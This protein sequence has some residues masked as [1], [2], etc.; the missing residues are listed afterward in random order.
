MKLNKLLILTYFSFFSF[1]AIFAQSNPN[2]YVFPI[3]TGQQNFLS[4]NMGE[5]R[6]NHFHAGIDIKTS[7]VEGLPVYAAAD[8]YISRIKM[9]AWGYG[10]AL[11][12]QHP[13]GETTVYAHLLR[14]ND[15]I[16]DYVRAQQYQQKTFE[17]ELFPEKNV[18]PISQGD[19]IAFSGNTGGSGGPHLHFE[20][21]D[22]NQ[23][24]LN[25]LSYTFSEIVDD[26]P[27][28]IDRIA[29]ITLEKDARINNQF[30]RFEFDLV[31][32]G[33]KYLI[34]DPIIVHGEVGIEVLGYDRANGT[35][36]KNGISIFETFVDDELLFYQDIAKFS[37]AESR[38]ILVFHNY[39][40]YRQ[41]GKRF[42]KLYVDEGNTLPFYERSPGKGRLV[43]KDSSS[44][45]ITIN[46]WDIYKNKSSIE[47]QLIS[48]PPVSRLQSSKK[49][50]ESNSSE[51]LKN[52]LKIT[53]AIKEGAGNKAFFHANRMVFDENPAYINNTHGVYLWD[54]K[55]GL[56][57]SVKIENQTWKFSYEA[58]VPA[59]KAFSLYNHYVNVYFPKRALYDTL[60][61]QTSYWQ[62]GD[63]EIFAVSEDIYPLRQSV[64]ITLKPSLAYQNLPKTHVYSVSGAGY[65]SFEGG[66]W[67]NSKIKFN[68]RNF[69]QFT[70]LQDTI[71]P[72]IKP[73]IVNKD[74]LK[75]V[76]RDER[77][78]IQSYEASID[79][80]WI[81]MYYDYKTRLIWSDKLKKDVAF[82]GNLEVK[83]KD[84]AG[85]EFVYTQKL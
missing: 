52:T 47:F 45:Q 77:S 6:N 44:H 25:P 61:L 34:K 74:E 13:N 12:I 28:Q 4:G 21:R 38:G 36:N 29:L 60:Y 50:K 80:Q 59:G 56:P 37:F 81:L 26:T 24:V 63:Q 84:Q 66:E 41:S 48:R 2:Y 5:L 68:T 71:A 51:I 82:S 30:G 8:G 20:I 31:R 85:N 7:G 23:E 79:G 67:Q 17:I 40:V 70:I 9:S 15:K 42:Y 46:A 54:L 32:S 35:N 10:N 19:V 69:G 1:T 53:A 18:F 72:T 78:G 43:F 58:M 33:T 64:S 14:Y 73:I 75:F 11:Y 39:P 55:R 49:E 62:D 22:K 27:P 57:D 76:I 16:Q 3:R 65:Y 83:V